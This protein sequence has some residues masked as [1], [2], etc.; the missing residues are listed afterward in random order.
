MER[1]DIKRL[2]V[3]IKIAERNKTS[4]NRFYLETETETFVFHRSMHHAGGFKK[5]IIVGS[6]LSSDQR[7]SIPLHDVLY[8]HTYC[9]DT[10]IKLT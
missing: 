4:C 2:I 3:I 10:I 7:T 8:R 5:K 6:K 1:G 9:T